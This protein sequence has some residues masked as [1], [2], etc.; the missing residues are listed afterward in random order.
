MPDGSATRDA[1]TDQARPRPAPPL[2]D[3]LRRG[4]WQMVR[5]LLFAPSPVPFHGWRR[6]LLRAFGAQVGARAAIYPGARIYAPW[7]LEIAEGATVGDGATLYSVD[8]IRLGPRAIVSQGAHLCTASHDLRSPGFELISAPIV[9]EADSWVAAEAF[10]GPGVTFGEGS[11]AGARAV[12]IRTV[13]SRAIVAGNPAREIGL[14]P[15]QGHNFLR[16]RVKSIA[17]A[18]EEPDASL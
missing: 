7:R 5:A 11:V 9:L 2:S 1:A 14:R 16:G 10:V 15:L 13:P 8:T 6:A 3:R 17:P 4:L 18:I 12:V